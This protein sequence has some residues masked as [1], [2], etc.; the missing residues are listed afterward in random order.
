MLLRQHVSKLP[1]EC[2][3][4]SA[5]LASV[6]MKSSQHYS[7][8]VNITHPGSQP[9]I[10][11]SSFWF[12]PAT[13]RSKE[14]RKQEIF[15]SS[16]WQLISLH[17]HVVYLLSCLSLELLHWFCSDSLFWESQE[18]LTAPAVN[19]PQLWSVPLIWNMWWLYFRCHDRVK[20]ETIWY[21]KQLSD[22]LTPRLSSTPDAYVLVLVRPS[23][24]V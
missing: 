17:Y 13:R 22:N 20:D 5:W 19:L 9:Q 4:F 8:P 15:F 3:Y 10:F 24:T 7:N 14:G 11:G 18:I 16:Y 1:A 6:W 2:L 12:W 21:I 23:D